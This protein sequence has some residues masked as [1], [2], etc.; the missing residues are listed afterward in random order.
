DYKPVKTEFYQPHPEIESLSAE[1]VAGLRTH[2]GRP[3][4]ITPRRSACPSPATSFAHLG[5]PEAITA[6][7][8]KAGYAQPTP[9]QSQALPAALSGRDVIGIAETGSG[10]TCAY[11]I[12]MVVHRT[13]RSRRWGATTGPS[14]WPCAPRGSS[15]SR[16]RRRG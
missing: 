15:P 10:K 5:L 2:P 4:Q 6:C 16:S 1:E 12:P 14:A 11:L 8:R 3:I 7:L 9:I 13:A